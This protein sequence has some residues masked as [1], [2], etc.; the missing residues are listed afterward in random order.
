MKKYE[1][2]I[3][4]EN[5]YGRIV[6]I[7]I[8]SNL[9]KILEKNSKIVHMDILQKSE[10]KFFSKTKN[11]KKE[12]TIEIS[13]LVKEYK[14]KKIDFLIMD[15]NDVSKYRKAFI[16]E[17]LLFSKN[18]IIFNFDEKVELEY[19]RYNLEIEKSDILKIKNNNKKP[20]KI[21]KILYNIKDTIDNL[22]GYLLEFLTL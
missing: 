22:L 8:S 7:G 20:S 4:K 19:K 14:K 10:P 2:E 17:T 11:N 13:Y 18:I 21:K 12:K 16:Y 9:I 3:E 15:F 6:T 1:K 5:I